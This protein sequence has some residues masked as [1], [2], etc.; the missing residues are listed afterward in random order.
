MI[1]IYSVISQ[2]WF[3]LRMVRQIM[4]LNPLIILCKFS[5]FIWFMVFSG[6][7]LSAK[8]MFKLQKRVLKILCYSIVRGILSIQL[9][10]DG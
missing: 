1:N 6:K 10:Y 7:P 8:K 2:I 5:L 4:H 3:A 9:N